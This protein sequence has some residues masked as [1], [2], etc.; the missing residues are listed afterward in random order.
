MLLLAVLLWDQ[1][2]PILARAPNRGRSVLPTEREERLPPR[3]ASLPQAPCSRSQAQQLSLPLVLRTS[4]VGTE[5]SVS[6][7]SVLLWLFP[8]PAS[9]CTHVHLTFPMLLC[10]PNS[11]TDEI[12]T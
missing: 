12:G 11:I 8:Y 5:A 9:T 7:F 6:M 4:A 1:L 2:R 10:F 3:R